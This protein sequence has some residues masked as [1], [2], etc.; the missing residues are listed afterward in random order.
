MTR[1]IEMNSQQDARLDQVV[2]V[3]FEV[4]ASKL[5][6]TFDNFT[7]RDSAL[8]ERQEPVEE[9]FGEAALEK[10]PDSTTLE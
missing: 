2:E 7:K 3:A 8:Q 9:E 10:H 4:A 6:K 5:G 1:L